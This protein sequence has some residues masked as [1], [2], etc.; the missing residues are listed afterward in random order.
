MLYKVS[1]LEKKQVVCFNHAGIQYSPLT[2]AHPRTMVL[3]YHISLP[4]AALLC[5]IPLS[6]L[7]G[8]S[9]CW[10]LISASL[11]HAESLKEVQAPHFP[12]CHFELCSTRPVY[13][14]GSHT[15]SLVLGQPQ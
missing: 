15:A 6:T 7:S 13:Y 3:S 10:S 9:H 8:C 2:V 4:T 12:L 14:S 5:S 11:W 1:L